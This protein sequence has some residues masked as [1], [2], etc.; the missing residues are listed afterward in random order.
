MSI[1]FERSHGPRCPLGQ[2]APHQQGE[3][4]CADHE[5]KH[6]GCDEE[7]PVVVVGLRARKRV[8][9]ALSAKTAIEATTTMARVLRL[10]VIAA[11]VMTLL[12]NRSS[13][14]GSGASPLS[15]RIP[16][17]STRQGSCRVTSTVLHV[18]RGISR[19][20]VRQS[21]PRPP[22]PGVRA[23]VGDRGERL[24]AIDEPGPGRTKNASASTAQSSTSEGTVPSR[25]ARPRGL[26]RRRVG[27]HTARR[28][29]C[30]VGP[31][32]AQRLRSDVTVVRILPVRSAHPPRSPCREPSAPR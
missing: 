14:T 6:R 21:A 20:R 32:R 9:G 24:D 10:C 25:A 3:G 23:E 2:V 11:A 16:L 28:Q 29:R 1:A 31:P 17:G 13:A 18:A 27:S 19:S 22:P 5:G 8:D 30:P 7:Q 26:L 12:W 4:D 15:Q